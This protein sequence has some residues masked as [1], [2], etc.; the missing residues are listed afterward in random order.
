ME[1]LVLAPEGRTEVRPQDLPESA[2][3][4]WP[5]IVNRL[6]ILASVDPVAF[7]TARAGRFELFENREHFWVR[8][9]FPPGAEPES[10]WLVWR[11]APVAA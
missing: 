3:I 1:K 8:V 6:K 4:D 7:P 11:P 9:E 5:R 10:V 2:R